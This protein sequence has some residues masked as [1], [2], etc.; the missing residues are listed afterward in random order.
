[1]RLAERFSELID[2]A[3][4]A[5]NDDLL[6]LRKVRCL[7]SCPLPCSVALRAPGK[8]GYRL[9]GLAVRDLDAVLLLAILH[10]RH[11]SGDL[12]G[13]VWPGRLLACVTVRTPPHP[14]PT[15]QSVDGELNHAAAAV[16]TAV[17]SASL[18]GRQVPEAQT[19][20]DFR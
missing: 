15:C 2:S 5:S 7:N 6:V 19:S 9:S 4:D 14:V 17:T 10:A 20:G 8:W 3:R 16:V 11:S 18:A 13:A 1:L 12:S